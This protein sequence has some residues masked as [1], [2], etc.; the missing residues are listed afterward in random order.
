MIVSRILVAGGGIGERHGAE[1]ELGADGGTVERGG[2][3]G[4]G[5]KE[6]EDFGEKVGVGRTELAGKRFSVLGWKLQSEA[7]GGLYLLIS[8]LRHCEFG[9]ARRVVPAS[10]PPK[11]IGRVSFHSSSF[12]M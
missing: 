10:Q 1:A 8:L 3:L 12:T 2:G 6:C 11:R 7:E 9:N 5:T 4:V